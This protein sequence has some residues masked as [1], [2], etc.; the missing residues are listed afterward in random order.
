MNSQDELICLMNDISRF[1]VNQAINRVGI[2]VLP[3]QLKDKNKVMINLLKNAKLIPLI[4][5]IK[6]II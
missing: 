2:E 1:Q 3:R 5:Y 6:L 4:K